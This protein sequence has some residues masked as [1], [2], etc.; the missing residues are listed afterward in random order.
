VA[1]FSRNGWPAWP[2]Y[3]H[4][5]GREEYQTKKSSKKGTTMLFFDARSRRRARKELLDLAQR[6]DKLADTYMVES[7]HNGMVITAG[8]L[9]RRINRR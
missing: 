3:A 1:G 9:T 8:H 7:T 5:H 2:E 4:R 6:F